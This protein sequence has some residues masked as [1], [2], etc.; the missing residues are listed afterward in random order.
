MTPDR[1]SGSTPCSSTVRDSANSCLASS[2]AQQWPVSALQE[3]TPHPTGQG[4]GGLRNG[5]RLECS[6]LP[7]HKACPEVLWEAGRG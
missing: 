6:Q 7:Q 5:P 1:S 4:Q 2:W 3:H